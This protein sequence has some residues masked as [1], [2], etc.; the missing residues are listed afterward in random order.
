[1]KT[2]LGLADFTYCLSKF[3]YKVMGDPEIVGATTELGLG[4]TQ[5]DVALNDPER[6][7]AIRKALREQAAAAGIRLVGATYGPP[8]PERMREALAAANELGADVLRYACGPIFIWQQPVPPAALRDALRAAAPAAEELGIALA[9]ENHQDYT[10]EELA[11]IMAEVGS[12]QIGVC[13]DTGNSLA[14]LEDPLHTARLLAP[15]VHQVHLKE[16]AVLAAP[17]GF[18]LTGVALGA[19]VVDNGGA[20]ALVRERAPVDRV[21]VTIENPLE[22]CRIPVLSAKYAT[23]MGGRT[24]A[25]MA[26][27]F[28]LMAASAEKFPDGVVLPQEAGLPETEVVAKERDHNRRAV[29]YARAELGL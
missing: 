1:M 23:K 11:A 20:L 12:P 27:I 18:D 8:T 2:V 29:A 7:P 21:Y 5:V 9:V 24:L 13:L 26:A 28:G 3:R 14:L 15:F 6:G 19:G 17:G 25:S 4:C 10:A 16:Y 22:R